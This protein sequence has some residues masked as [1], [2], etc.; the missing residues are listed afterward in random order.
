MRKVIFI[1]LISLF[2]AGCGQDDK[3]DNGSGDQTES[4]DPVIGVR[5][6][7][8]GEVVYTLDALNA[9]RAAVQDP[10]AQP[11][12][13]DNPPSEPAYVPEQPSYPVSDT[14]HVPEQPA[15]VAPSASDRENSLASY[16]IAARAVLSGAVGDRY[17]ADFGYDVGSIV[18]YDQG[19]T[20]IMGLE[21]N[22]EQLAAQ[23]GLEGYNIQISTPVV[24]TTVPT[25][26]PTPAPTA[27]P[28]PSPEPEPTPTPT[29]TPTPTPESTS[30]LTPT[31]TPTPTLTPTPTPTPT[32]EPTPTLTPSVV[33]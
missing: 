14:Y 13:V 19:S 4:G 12:S 23:L 18:L 8:T 10:Q 15:E 16:S 31:P 28:M 3:T 1:L 29:A 24:P 25:M 22:L 21:R 30:T 17:Q 5:I 6:D 32:P 11:A 33:L 9:S 26:E 20:D 27:E 7:G 2:L